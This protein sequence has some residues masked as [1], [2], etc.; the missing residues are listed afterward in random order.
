MPIAQA[1]LQVL[2]VCKL[3]QCVRER[4]KKQIEKLTINGTPQLIN[5]NAAEDG[6]TALIVAANNND[7]DMIEFLLGLGAHP[8]VMDLKGK[9]AAIWAAEYGNVECLE[10]LLAAGANMTL[11]DI[12]G[13]GMLSSF[14]E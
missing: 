3:L 5:Y 12:E 13:K 4:N 11:T 6:L 14:Y 7:D 9:T 8:D 2:Q 10:K 1:R